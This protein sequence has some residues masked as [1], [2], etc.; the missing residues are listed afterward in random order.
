MNE[1]SSIEEVIAKSK[2]KNSNFRLMGFGHRVYKN[3]DPRATIMQKMCHNVLKLVGDTE[4][5]PLLDLA[6]NLEKKALSDE[7]FIKRKLY[8]NVDFYT[9]IVYKAIGIPKDMFTVLF[10]VSR[11]AGWMAHWCEMM[12]ENLNRI[13]RPRQMYV[14]EKQTDY[15]D[16]LARKSQDDSR[17]KSMPKLCKLTQLM[18]L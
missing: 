10:A 5:A 18:K 17:V 4:T 15:E 11:S 1:G 2:D 7:Y 12:N 13:S 3:F 6:I 14:G 9:G 8:P 16:I